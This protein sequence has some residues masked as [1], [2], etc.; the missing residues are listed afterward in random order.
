MAKQCY[1]CRATLNDD[2]LFCTKCGTKQDVNG[3]TC[4]NCGKV[5]TKDNAVFCVYC[6]AKLNEEIQTETATSQ[7][8]TTPTEEQIE[9]VVQQAQEEDIVTTGPQ[10]STKKNIL[11]T[12]LLAIF[13][14]GIITAGVVGVIYLPQYNL[15]KQARTE[16]YTSSYNKYVR[17]YPS[18]MYIQEARD[19]IAVRNKRIQ[20]PIIEAARKKPNAISGWGEY[21]I[22]Y[23]QGI[24]AIEAQK[25]LVRLAK[26]NPLSQQTIQYVRA[27]TQQHDNE[28]TK[29]LVDIVYK[30]ALKKNTI[31]AWETFINNTPSKYHKDAKKHLAKAREEAA[32]RNACKVNTKAAYEEYMEK[33]PNGKYAEEANSRFLKRS[34]KENAEDLLNILDSGLEFLGL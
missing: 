34:V 9:D 2:A 25:E 6:G 11:T 23:P 1:K 5:T 15:I 4:P 30:Q 17:K 14:V 3:I 10:T 18:G 19:S 13:I 21:L 33:Y 16:N 22:K 31:T 24:Y 20:T 28:I 8:T 26:A 27:Y 12:V 29:Q 7:D 32:W